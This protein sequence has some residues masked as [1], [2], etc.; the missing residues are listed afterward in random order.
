MGN[1]GRRIV[2]EKA[3]GKKQRG[4]K[5]VLRHALLFSCS[6]FKVIFS[7][8]VRCIRIEETV[9]LVYGWQFPQGLYPFA[10]RVSLDSLDVP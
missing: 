2:R 9:F 3:A 5:K 10:I 7:A 1:G 4:E 8:S 6:L